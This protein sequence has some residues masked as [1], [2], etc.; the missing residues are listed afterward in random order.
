MGR[1]AATIGIAIALAAVGMLFFAEE[2]GLLGEDDAH[3]TLFQP[4]GETDGAAASLQGNPGTGP[5]R[6]EIAAAERAK[7][8]A[9]EAARV[10]VKPSEGVHGRVTDGSGNPLADVRVGL[11]P[12]PKV[13]KQWGA[14]PTATATG[15]T[16][17]AGEFVVGPA[18]SSGALLIRAEKVGYAATIALV[19]K[20]GTRVDLVLDKGGVLRVRVLD[21]VGEAIAG[22]SVL[23]QVGWGWEAI[24][25]H[26]RTNEAGEIL[27]A[28]VPTGSGSLV[29][30]AKGHAAARLGDVGT[31]PGEEESRTVLLEPQ[32]EVAGKVV[33]ATTD[34]PIEGASVQIHYP[35]LSMLEPT[36]AVQTEADGRF[37]LMVDVNTGE[38]VQFRVS[39]EKYAAQRV[40]RNVQTE[41]DVTLKL[42]EPDEALEGTVVDEARRPVGGAKVVYF[43]IGADDVPET[44]TDERGRFTLPLPPWSV[45]GVQLLAVAPG[46]GMG[47]TWLRIKQKPGARR[48]PV[49]IKLSGGGTVEG[50]VT[51]KDGEPAEGALVKVV[52]DGQASQRLLGPQSNPWAIM[53]VLNEGRFLDP[54][55]VTDATGR[56]TIPGVPPLAYRVEAR[57]GLEEA[58]T[59]EAI[60]VSSGAIMTA[61][62]QLGEGGT[63]EGYVMDVDERPVPGA[64]VSAR[65]MNRQSRGWGIRQ[66]TARV[67]ADG[68][69]VLRGIGDS[70]YTLWVSASGYGGGSEKNVRQGARDVRITIKKL[71]WIQGQVQDE[72]GVFRGTFRIHVKRTQQ[73]QGNTRGWYGGQNQFTFNTDDGRFVVRGQQEGEYEVRASTPDGLISLQQEKVRVVNGQGTADIQLRMSRGATVRGRVTSA[74]TGEPIA[75]AWV[76]FTARAGD[77]Q[78]DSSG[79]TSGGARANTKGEYQVRGLGGGAYT[80]SVSSP[81]GMNWSVAVDLQFGE[82]RRLDLV[83]QQPGTIQIFVTDVDGNP[84]AQAQPSVRSETGAWVWPNWNALRR[85]GLMGNGV[86]WQMLNQTDETGVN[87]RYHV[88][89]GRYEIGVSK[90]GLRLKGEKPWVDVGSG[91]QSEVTL[92]MEKTE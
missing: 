32:K 12:R 66:P 15:K 84:I 80:V 3:E 18:P 27:F 64:M 8:E 69:F 2:L 59:E 4:E 55:A 36:E 38:Q 92:V 87:I 74:A 88:P 46:K 56:F 82:T 75:G 16:N 47:L 48:P 91:R 89:P 39:H 78:G 9:E 83:Q 11:A 44:K 81:N 70:D 31:A 41:T 72:G 60:T 5:T 34:M 49:E 29:V 33:D 53:N 58:R 10:A 20:R 22:A 45:N 30:S 73:Q 43:G 42:S 28:S 76:G 61:D 77:S 50:I 52:V 23:H 54:T 79:A 86:S 19:P 71:G 62:I 25:N 85:D 6:A 51:G 7:R 26:G 37:K 35:N 67:Q 1:L 40:T 63:I 57:H 14:P 13:F 68:R 21:H 24:L 17:E 65:P 90:S